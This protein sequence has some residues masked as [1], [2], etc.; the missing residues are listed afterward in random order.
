MLEFV[1][2]GVLVLAGALGQDVQRPAVYK[3][4]DRQLFAV[5]AITVPGLPTTTPKSAQPA[6]RHRHT[7]VF[8]P[9]QPNVTTGPCNMPIIVGDAS[10]DP[11]ILIPRQTHHGKSKVRIVEPKACG[12][13]VR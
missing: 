9:K 7:D 6:P 13:K 12:E 11:G 2:V 4:G 3:H 10:A 8:G 1:G 5:P